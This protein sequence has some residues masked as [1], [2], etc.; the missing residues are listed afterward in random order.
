M[1]PWLLVT[2]T[3]LAIVLG[4][5]SPVSSF[6]LM[7]GSR[8]AAGFS[9][10]SSSLSHETGASFYAHSGAGSE[11][12][13]SDASTGLAT[14]GDS[15][16]SMAASLIAS[17]DFDER[18]QA[19]IRLINDSNWSETS[20]AGVTSLEGGTAFDIG[21]WF[22]S[23]TAADFDSALEANWGEIQIL[24]AAIEAN[25]AFS[26]W[27]DGLGM[28]TGSVVTVGQTADGS[29]AVFTSGS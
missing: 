7:I 6:E 2:I 13:G 29:L 10:G 15:S 28:D 26:A 21:G 8:T 11:A 24:H 16:A 19:V 17:A 18:M 27:L 5:V 23:G 1:S 14:A 3:S 20:F 4:A 25:G 9:S 22:T 12:S